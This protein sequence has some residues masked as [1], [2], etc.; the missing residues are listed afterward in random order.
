MVNQLIN[1]VLQVKK[2]TFNPNDEQSRKRAKQK[3][4]LQGIAVQTNK[5]K[6]DK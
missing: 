2:Y 6:K 3:A 4:R 5:N 1:M